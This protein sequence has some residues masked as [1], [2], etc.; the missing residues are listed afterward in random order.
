MFCLNWRLVFTPVTLTS[1]IF[2][3]LATFLPTELPEV[4]INMNNV[5][6]QSLYPTIHHDPHRWVKCLFYW[7]VRVY[8][9]QGLDPLSPRNLA[10]FKSTNIIY[11]QVSAVCEKINLQQGQRAAI[12]IWGW[13][14]RGWSEV[15]SSVTAEQWMLSLKRNIRRGG[16]QDQISV[17]T[18]MTCVRSSSQEIT[19]LVPVARTE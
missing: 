5:S 19:F 15:A 13:E 4:R 8:L 10:H 1:L 9:W 12:W 14:L 18:E 2:S 16:E 3:I 11:H 17:L 6:I 7:N